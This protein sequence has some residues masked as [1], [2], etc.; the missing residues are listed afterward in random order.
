MTSDDPH[1]PDSKARQ[2]ARTW[3]LR[4]AGADIDAEGLDALAQWRKSHWR[5][6]AAFEEERRLYR[7]LQPL[8]LAFAAGGLEAEKP[9]DRPR[10]ARVRPVAIGAGIA[11]AAAVTWAVTDPLVSLRADKVT[12]VGEIAQLE[13]PDGS[14]AILNT[15]SALAV[16]FDRKERRIHLLRGEAWFKVA[17]DKVHPFIVDASGTTARAVGTAFSVDRGERGETSLLV[18][19]GRVRFAGDGQDSLDVDAG[20]GAVMAEGTAKP[21][22]ISVEPEENLSW[23][24]G[25]L[26]FENRSLA[27]VAEMLGR[28]RRGRIWV[29][30]DAAKRRVSGVLQV[31]AIDEGLAGL[32]AAQGLRVTYVT[33]WLIILR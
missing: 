2:V 15:D 21:R 24:S 6:E 3:I 9:R 22:A 19:E 10:R 29:L 33:P 26:T 31:G 4:L 17:H 8:D 16:D 32:A 28:Y 30:G 14:T 23:R 18:T 20:Q 27:E 1:N 7:S 13:L 11:A 5:H 12:G 25:R